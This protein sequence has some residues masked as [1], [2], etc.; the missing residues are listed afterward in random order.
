[1]W[2]KDSLI[3][4]ENEQF[5]Q[6]QNWFNQNIQKYKHWIQQNIFWSTKIQTKILCLKIFILLES[7]SSR[8]KMLQSIKTY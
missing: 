1:M 8:L 6:L 2:F 4:A 5:N 7:Y 3:Q